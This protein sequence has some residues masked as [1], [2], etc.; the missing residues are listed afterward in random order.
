M[1]TYK[2]PPPLP[3]ISLNLNRGE[4]VQILN[5]M[6]QFLFKLVQSD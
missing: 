1:P 6:A 3:R 2:R 5:E 4:G